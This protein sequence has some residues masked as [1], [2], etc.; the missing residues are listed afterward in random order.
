MVIILR[1]SSV[2]YRRLVCGGKPPCHPIE[3]S[4]KCMLFFQRDPDIFRGRRIE[5]DL[6][7]KWRTATLRDEFG[8]VGYWQAHRFKEI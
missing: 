3:R 7:T 6:V 1:I 2:F 8:G 4:G 5:T